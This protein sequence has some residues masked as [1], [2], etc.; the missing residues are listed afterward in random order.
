MEPRRVV[1]LRPR[2][3]ITSLNDGEALG[4]ICISSLNNMG[5]HVGFSR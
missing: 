1:A 2:L 4:I 3:L 5:V